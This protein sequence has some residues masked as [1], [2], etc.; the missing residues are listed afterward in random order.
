VSAAAEYATEAMA[1]YDALEG[2]LE[3]RHCVELAASGISPDVAKLRGYA[4]IGKKTANSLKIA[5]GFADYQCRVPGMVL[6]I[7]DV[8]GKLATA[9]YK[10][11]SSRLNKKKPPQ[12]IKYETV[13]D[14]RVLI[15][16]P[17]IVQPDLGDPSKP[18]WITE[19]IKKADSA[20]SHG[21]VCIGLTGVWNWRGT[22]EGGGKLVLPDW[23]GI[24][25]NDRKIYLAFDSDVTTKNS[26]QAALQRLA[27]FLKAKGAIVFIVHIPGGLDGK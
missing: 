10:P 22:N 5:Y 20:V 24:A 12:P 7:F 4:T 2:K 13:A 21:L 15:D 14:S 27:A 3:R 18:L 6:P 19:G 23:D 11:D 1:I 8:F 25:L 17:Q 9:Q 16:V 26:V